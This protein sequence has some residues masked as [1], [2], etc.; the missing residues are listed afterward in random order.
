MRTARSMKWR[1]NDRST[2]R[3]HQ[4][5]ERSSRYEAD[6]VGMTAEK[7][8]QRYQTYLDKKFDGY[9]SRGVQGSSSKGYGAYRSYSREAEQKKTAV[10]GN[11]GKSH[12]QRTYE[13]LNE[14]QTSRRTYRD[15]TGYSRRSRYSDRDDSR[16]H[17]R[18]KYA[19]NAPQNLHRAV[20]EN[21][22]YNSREASFTRKDTL[23]TPSDTIVSDNRRGPSYDAKQQ[24]GYKSSRAYNAESRREV[25]KKEAEPVKR[26]EQPKDHFDRNFVAQSTENHFRRDKGKMSLEET[27][28]KYKDHYENFKNILGSGDYSTKKVDDYEN[29]YN[30]Y[31]RIM[32][33]PEEGPKPNK[34]ALKSRQ[35]VS[36]SRN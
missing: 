20:G 22:S 12:L 3:P 17:R 32:R 34:P 11:R 23:L 29:R 4:V 16:S 31:K 6:S 2:S 14:T 30:R 19:E 27:Q 35:E 28:K 15:S 10:T 5:D 25:P 26:P 9:R 24:N 18:L 8:S 1:K 21:K 36:A 7:Y 33:G 13:I